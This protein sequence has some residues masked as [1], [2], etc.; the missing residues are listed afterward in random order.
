MDK[1]K[2]LPS[3]D[4]ITTIIPLTSLILSSHYIGPHILAPV[5]IM[6]LLLYP[7]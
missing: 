2:S 6:R 3:N 4:V 5:I 1:I 7:P